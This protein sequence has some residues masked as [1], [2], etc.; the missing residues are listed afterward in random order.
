MYSRAAISPDTI[1]RTAYRHEPCNIPRTLTRHIS[2]IIITI[3]T[4]TTTT[5]TTTNTNNRRI[6]LSC[7]ASAP[8]TALVQTCLYIA[9][10]NSITVTDIR[11]AMPKPVC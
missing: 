5:T 6:Q 7:A 9:V 11:S 3:T 4:T 10:K 2:I 8:A 1:G